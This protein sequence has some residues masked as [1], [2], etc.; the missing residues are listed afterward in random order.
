M[1]LLVEQVLLKEN[2]ATLLGLIYETK[3]SQS[4]GLFHVALDT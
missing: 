4:F 2:S 3:Q 1:N